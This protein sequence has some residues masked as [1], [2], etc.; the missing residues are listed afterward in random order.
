MRT[1]LSLLLPL[2]TFETLQH[3]WKPRVGKEQAAQGSGDLDAGHVP[4]VD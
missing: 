1:L 3:P 4:K 2:S